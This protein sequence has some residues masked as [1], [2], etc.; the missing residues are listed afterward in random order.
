[1]PVKRYVRAT[2]PVAATVVRPNTN[3]T[4]NANPLR[5][6]IVHPPLFA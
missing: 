5:A 3:P 4:K 2:I 1:L 6:L